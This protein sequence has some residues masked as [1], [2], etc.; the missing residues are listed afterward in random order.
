MSQ[1]AIAA[2]LLELVTPK[3]TQAG[4]EYLQASTINKDGSHSLMVRS[5]W[6]NLTF[7]F[8]LFS[9]NLLTQYVSGFLPYFLLFYLAFF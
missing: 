3:G 7:F 9:A 2:L 1:S 6:V 8:K 4:K 5:L